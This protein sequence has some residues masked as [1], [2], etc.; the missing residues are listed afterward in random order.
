MPVGP[1]KGG[2]PQLG[3]QSREGPFRY[4]Q[5]I[6]GS[7]EWDKEEGPLGR[8]PPLGM[9]KEKSHPNAS[10][11]PASNPLTDSVHAAKLGHNKVVHV[12]VLAEVQFHQVD[13]HLLHARK[14]HHLRKKHE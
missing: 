5:I 7:Q 9:R 2:Q 3:C 6:G 12:T 1:P 8:L 13:L 4:L 10:L 11:N 14:V